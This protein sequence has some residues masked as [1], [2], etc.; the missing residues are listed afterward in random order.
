[1]LPYQI[2]LLLNHLTEKN[3]L[4]YCKNYY[5]L[6]IDNTAID[7]NIIKSIYFDIEST[8]RKV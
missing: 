7:A 8:T 5:Q 4:L 6:M 2:L 3:I 1:M